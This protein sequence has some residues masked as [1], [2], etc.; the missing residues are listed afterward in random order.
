MPYRTRRLPGGHV[1]V[2]G[3]GGRLVAR[4]TTP[5]RARRQLRL[6]RGLEHGTIRRTR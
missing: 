1:R 2:T 3:P 6:L 5:A 4:S